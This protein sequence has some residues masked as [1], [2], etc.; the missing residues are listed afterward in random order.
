M[1]AAI[2]EVSTDPPDRPRAHDAHQ[3][4]VLE[5]LLEMLHDR[6]ER[7]GV[8]RVRALFPEPIHQVGRGDAS[9]L[10]LAV[11]DEEDLGHEDEIRLSE[12]VGELVQKETGSTVLMRL[13]DADE[14]ERAGIIK[15][16]L[17]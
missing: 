16:L 7:M 17:L 3:I 12:G 2:D 13:E 9:S 15:D 4:V 8:H 6:G 11:P 5:N 10:L 14:S 1:G